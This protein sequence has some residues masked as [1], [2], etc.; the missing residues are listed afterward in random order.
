MKPLLIMIGAAPGTGKSSVAARLYTKLSPSVWLDADDLWRMNPFVITTQ[1]KEMVLRN[2][3]LMLS[4]FLNESFSYIIFTWVMHEPWI[5]QDL[6]SRLTH[7]D[8][9]LLH[10]TLYCSEQE[11]LRRLAASSLKRDPQVC[12]D[13]LRSIR[14]NYPD[15]IDTGNLSTDAVVNLLMQDISAKKADQNSHL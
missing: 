2:A 7:T 9:C 1:S 14:Q 5:I 8:Y 3:A 13:R 4:S 12:L 10:Y 15:A 11:L 6:L